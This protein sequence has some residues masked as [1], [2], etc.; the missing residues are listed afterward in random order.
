MSRPDGR[1]FWAF[2]LAVYGRAGVADACLELQDR[3]GVDVNLLLFGCWVGA[4]GGGR[5]GEDDWRR[6]I[7]D[8][9]AWRDGVVEP[10]RGVRRRLKAGP[11]PGFE[12][13]RAVALREA[14]K[15]L[16]L[17]AEYAEQLAIAALRPITPEASVG[18]EHSSADALANVERYMA[19]LGASPSGRDRANMDLVIAAS[20]AVCDKM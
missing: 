7:I 10:L 20:V 18:P 19:A 11:W 4:R 3:H 5:L 13:Q 16:E 12:P 14:A 6:L 15:R 2:S 17:E 9:G 1:E 8:T